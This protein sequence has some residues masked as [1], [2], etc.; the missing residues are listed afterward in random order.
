MVVPARVAEGAGREKICPP[1]HTAVVVTSQRV[2]SPDT[3][4]YVTRSKDEHHEKPGLHRN[5]RSFVRRRYL[6]DPSPREVAR[7]NIRANMQGIPAAHNTILC[8]ERCA[9]PPPSQ[10]LYKGLQFGCLEG[11]WEHV[12]LPPD[13][14]CVS[15]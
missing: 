8:R 13:C 2:T 3:L 6:I 4:S 9:F 1:A 5:W 7:A 10:N 12:D 11:A 14:I 15:A